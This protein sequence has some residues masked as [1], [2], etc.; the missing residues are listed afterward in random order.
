MVGAKRGAVL[1]AVCGLSWL[2]SACGGSA[3][4]DSP[5]NAGAGAVDSAAGAAG[6]R[7][8]AGDGGN[9]GEGE[10]ACR[11]EGNGIQIE[12]DRDYTPVCRGMEHSIALRAGGLSDAAFTCC[13][14]FDAAPQVG[15]SMS[16]QLEEDL[17]GHFTFSVPSDA[18]LGVQRLAL[19]CGAG[20]TLQPHLEVY[21]RPV[22][23]SLSA[24]V[25][26][27]D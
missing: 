5:S 26:A 7:A 14:A 17:S 20:G 1:A 23:S 22:L 21:E 18:P 10:L 19:T 9:A 12:P 3:K 24:E 13:A 2:A 4:T 27:T 16:A 15:F 11:P 25:H 6:E 8:D